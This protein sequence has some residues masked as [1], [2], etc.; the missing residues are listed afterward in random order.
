MF[1]VFRDD[2]FGNNND[3]VESTPS[4]SAP[5]VDNIGDKDETLADEVEKLYTVPN[6]TGEYYS[7]IIENEENDVFVFKIK[8]AEYSTQP[9][10]TVCSQSVAKGSSV[11][12]ET[13]IE[14][15]ISLGYKEF[16][17]PNVLNKDEINA[18]LE[19]LKSGFLYPNIEV[20]EKYD[21]DYEPGQVIEQY[22]AAGEMVNANIGVKIYIN[23]YE[24]DDIEY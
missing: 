15:V 10:G 3:D 13:E 9:R 23:K 8:N 4:T 11:K 24:G 21:E 17:M 12:K 20:L 2:I 14:L 16:K 19:L 5:V 22:P 18:K 1:T 6:F 7:S